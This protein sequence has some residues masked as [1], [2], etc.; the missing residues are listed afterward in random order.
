[1][2]ETTTETT[3]ETETKPEPKTYAGGCHCGKVRYEAQIALEKLMDCNCSICGKTGALL[4][5]I[6]AGQFK[7]LSGEDAVTD[8]QFAKKH[9][10]HTFCATC[11]I[12]SYAH[13][14]GPDGNTMFA[15]N[16]RCLDDVDVTSVPVTHHDGKSL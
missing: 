3:T 12:R 8:Y 15:I 9:I 6:P 5:F 7:L 16:V 11:G 10:H 14:A 2:S 13:G 4:A 1:M